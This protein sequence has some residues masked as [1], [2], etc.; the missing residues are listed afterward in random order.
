MC[1]CLL[2]I[3]MLLS[4][5]CQQLHQALPGHVQPVIRCLSQLAATCSAHA[6]D[7]W[8]CWQPP[9][10]KRLLEH[11]CSQQEHLEVHHVTSVLRDVIQ[12]MCLV[13]LQRRRQQD[14]QQQQ[15][16]AF[17]QTTA[18]ADQGAP[19]VPISEAALQVS[20]SSGAVT[21]QPGSSYDSHD[22]SCTGRHHPA[23]ADT[24]P[25]SCTADVSVNRALS[26]DVEEILERLAASGGPQDVS[27]TIAVLAM[28]APLLDQ[29][30]LQQGVEGL[31]CLL[32]ASASQG[33]AGPTG[34]S[35]GQLA[36][37]A[38][39]PAPAGTQHVLL[40]AGSG[41]GLSVAPSAGLQ[42]G[43]AGPLQGL[44]ASPLLPDL[45]PD[46]QFSL[47]RALIMPMNPLPDREVSC[48][49]SSISNVTDG[50]LGGSSGSGGLTPAAARAV[51]SGSGG[52]RGGGS[53]E[54]LGKV[55]LPTPAAAGSADHLSGGGQRSSAWS[56][57]S[58]IAELGLAGVQFEDVEA[59]PARSPTARSPTAG[60]EGCCLD[61]P[62]QQMSGALEAATPT[63]AA[64]AAAGGPPATAA[65]GALHWASHQDREGRAPAQPLSADDSA[66]GMAA[67]APLA[68]GSWLHL[69]VRMIPLLLLLLL[70]L[71]MMMMMM[72]AAPLLG[73]RGLPH[74]RGSGHLAQQLQPAAWPAAPPA[75]T[76]PGGAAGWTTSRR[77]LPSS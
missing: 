67:G 59:A 54:L 8:I 74:H 60:D 64:A 14:D 34:R 33:Q 49:T 38:A 6:G 65:G 3:R 71:M 21:S 28:M 20:A 16:Q 75:W 50:S 29:L 30:G 62:H 17:E 35:Q 19:A 72:M 4:T 15:Q 48:S 58:I 27:S 12:V 70:L 26:E 44:Q 55:Q 45:I 66:V 32:P 69:L 68:R 2:E 63:A 13:D 52:S 53:A 37:A 9:L 36:A 76:T 46:R 77:Q 51:L 61:S 43:A 18:A 25:S 39:A 40:V 23:P 10:L 1:N 24:S 56:E 41:T 5:F 47:A 11:L 73:R 22:T 42:W 7:S 31:R 57:I